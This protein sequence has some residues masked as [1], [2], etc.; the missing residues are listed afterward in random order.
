M[1]IQ[2]YLWEYQR[3]CARFARQL[4]FTWNVHSM[5]RACCVLLLQVCC[6]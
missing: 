4:L 2:L 3:V 5:L 1:T 6:S